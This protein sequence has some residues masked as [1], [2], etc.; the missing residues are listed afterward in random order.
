MKL[1]QRTRVLVALTLTFALTLTTALGATIFESDW[2]AASSLS[3][4]NSTQAQITLAAA[5]LEGRAGAMGKNIQGKAQ[6]ARGNVLS[7]PKD[8]AAGKAKQAE[9]NVRNVAE[10]AKDSGASLQERVGATAKN[11][12]GGVQ[13]TV[14]NIAGDPQNQAGGKAKQAEGNVR[15]AVEDVKR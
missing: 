12:Q 1:L 3:L 4:S 5:D 10:D 6:E 7:D 11:I 14:G 2:A 13:D 15:N 8:R 9:G